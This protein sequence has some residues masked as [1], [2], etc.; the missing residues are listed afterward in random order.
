MAT[1]TKL[2]S[3]TKKAKPASGI[4]YYEN[5]FRTM[6]R[7]ADKLEVNTLPEVRVTSSKMLQAITTFATWTYASFGIST[8][9]LPYTPKFERLINTINAKFG[10]CL[11]GWHVWQ[12][13][14]RARK[15]SFLPLSGTDRKTGTLM[16]K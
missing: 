4:D 1:K 12:I 13:L 2:K 8:D 15:S 14:L 11:G 7:E 10:V 5:L 6:N 16:K 9:N 3:K